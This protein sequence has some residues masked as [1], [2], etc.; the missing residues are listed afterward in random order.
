MKW[1]GCAVLLVICLPMMA[2]C[3]VAVGDFGADL[4]DVELA[5][6]LLVD[7][8]EDDENSENGGVTATVQVYHRDKALEPQYAE[9]YYRVAATGDDLAGALGN[10]PGR[11]AGQ[12]NFAHTGLL[13]L[14]QEAANPAVWLDFAQKSGALRPT[15]Y[16]VVVPGRAA[17]WASDLAENGGEMDALYLLANALE[18]AAGGGPLAVTLQDFAT[19][20]VTPG[21]AAALPRAL[22]DD[23]GVRVAGLYVWDGAA[24]HCLDDSDVVQAWRLLV[25]ARQVADEVIELEGATVCV[26][27]ARVRWQVDGSALRAAVTLQGRV[28]QRHNDLHGELSVGEIERRLCAR[29]C[30]MV[31]GAVAV[32]RAEN[33]DFLGLGREIWRYQ[34]ELWQEMSEGFGNYL[35]ALTVDVTVQAEV[36]DYAG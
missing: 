26:Q 28:A 13:V 11:G 23:D 29:V 22:A 27:A 10:L 6:A 9:S 17:D 35:A 24:W 14:G 8:A 33:V 4:K 32:S 15:V 34:P 21:V 31:L 5:A 18:P 20:L 30:D 12:L 19:A 25:R 36:T 16:P 2:G 3:G 1:C 7:V